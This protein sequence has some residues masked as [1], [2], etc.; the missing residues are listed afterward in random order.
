MLELDLSNVQFSW[1]DKIKDVVLPTVLSEEL[2]EDIGI[3]IGDGA[4]NVYKNIGSIDYYYKCS[5]HPQNEKPWFD[6]FSTG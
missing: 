4:M 5:G 6:N 3:H 1:K 2:A